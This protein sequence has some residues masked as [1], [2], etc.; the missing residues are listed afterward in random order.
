MT[1][2]ATEHNTVLLVSNGM[3]SICFLAIFYSPTLL[4]NVHIFF[5]VNYVP[6]KMKFLKRLQD[7]SVCL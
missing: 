4:Q 7:F 2:S 1:S 6:I 3:P 5:C